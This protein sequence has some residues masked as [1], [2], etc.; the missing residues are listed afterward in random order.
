MSGV[1]SL[2]RKAQILVQREASRREALRHIWEDRLRG[3]RGHNEAMCKIWAL[4]RSPLLLGGTRPLSPFLG[5][6][7][8]P[9]AMAMACR[10]PWQPPSIFATFGVLLHKLLFSLDACFSNLL[11]WWAYVSVLLPVK[12]FPLIIKIGIYTGVELV[13]GVGGGDDM[14][15]FCF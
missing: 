6:V 14:S 8:Q 5:A 10:R 11:Y 12:R 4:Q 13:Y 15:A 9:P 3:E 7:P 2:S 1:Q